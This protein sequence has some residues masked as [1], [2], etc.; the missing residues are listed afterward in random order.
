MYMVGIVLSVHGIVLSVH[1]IVLSVHCIV[2]SVHEVLSVAMCAC[3]RT[4]ARRSRCR[5]PWRARGR[6]SG[7]W[8]PRPRTH[9]RRWRRHT[10]MTSRRRPKQL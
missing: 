5:R 1:C 9:S 7:R 6:G 3:C 2:L 10:L 4:T 8:R